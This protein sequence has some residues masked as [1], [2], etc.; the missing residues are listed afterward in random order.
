MIKSAS[1]A[2][3][4][5]AFGT[6]CLTL[7]SGVILLVGF[8]KRYSLEID[9][10]EA[11]FDTPQG[12][13]EVG[14]VAKIAPDDPTFAR[15]PYNAYKVLRAQN[16]N[17]TAYIALLPHRY[18]NQIKHDSR[19]GETLRIVSIDY[20]LSGVQYPVSF[21]REPRYPEEKY[22]QYDGLVNY[23]ALVL[24]EPLN[25]I[26]PVVQGG[27]IIWK[28]IAR[29]E[30]DQDKV[31]HL[32]IHFLL[33]GQRYTIDAKFRILPVVKRFIALPGLGAMP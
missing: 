32:V 1:G 5:S 10:L 22:G 18:S 3:P 20:E 23:H 17:V 31:H 29:A 21:Y 27:S 9:L 12:A 30:Q 13:G 26:N 2:I 15:D 6:L 25:A 7:L 24:P 4:K 11:V 16:E 33:D 8:D 19:F 28:T 14:I